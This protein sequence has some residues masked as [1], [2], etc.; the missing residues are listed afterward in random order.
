MFLARHRNIGLDTPVFIFQIEENP[1]YVDLTHQVFTWIGSPRNIAVTSTITMLEVL[2]QP[3]RE[4]DEERIDN[5][6]AMLSTYPHL[7][8]IDVNLD[9]ADRAAQVRA[10]FNLRTPDAI[11]AATALVAASTGF[12]SNDPAF[13]RIPDLEVIIL[14]D[15]L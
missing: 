15:L 10:R 1:K 9:I 8:W 5:F 2:V 6:Y 12:I 14:D 13:R 3:H 11:Q 4:S 7:R